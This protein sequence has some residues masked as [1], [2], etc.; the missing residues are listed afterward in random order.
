MTRLQAR[1]AAALA[2]AAL[3]GGC[4]LAHLKAPAITPETVTLT[5]VRLDQQQFDVRLHVDNP[6][7]RPLPIK[8]VSCTLEVEGVEVGKGESAAPFVIPALG[9]NDFDLH[10]T[11]NLAVSV[12][13]L[14]RRVLQRGQLPEY[15]FSGWVNPDEAL[16]PPIPFSKSG[17]IQAEQL[18]LH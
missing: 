1:L 13:N 4:S 17:Q 12:P 6:N 14:L 11:T 9:S 16:L 8:S 18:Q 15:H 7:D 2:A 5:D 3:L 10:V